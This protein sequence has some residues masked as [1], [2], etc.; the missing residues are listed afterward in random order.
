MQKRTTC[1]EPKCRLATIMANI[2]QRLEEQ[3]AIME[4]QTLVIHELQQGQNARINEGNGGPDSGGPG[5]REPGNEGTEGSD[6]K[7]EET[8]VE[9][10]QPR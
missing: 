1:R 7:E 9:M 3:A 6:S 2:Q 4:Q 5:N 8:E 10:E